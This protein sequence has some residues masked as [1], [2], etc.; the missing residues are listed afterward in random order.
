LPKVKNIKTLSYDKEGP[1]KF[2]EK[3]SGQNFDHP[4]VGGRN[5]GKTSRKKNI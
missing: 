2:A 5:F 3:K 4:P 1:L